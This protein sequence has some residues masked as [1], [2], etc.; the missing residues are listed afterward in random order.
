MQFSKSIFVMSVNLYMNE[1]GQC[2]M[3]N[4][5]LFD[6][7]LFIHSHVHITK[8]ASVDNSIRL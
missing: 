8:L 7:Q 3:N 4:L 5:C 6:G 1:P 2:K